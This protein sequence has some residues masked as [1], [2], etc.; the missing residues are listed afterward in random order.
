MRPEKKPLILIFLIVFIDLVGFGIVIPLHSYLS[1]QFGADPFQVGLLMSIYSLMQFLFAPFWGQ[2]SDRYGRRPILLMSLLGAAVAHMGFAFANSYLL[3]FI[4][5][6]FAGLFG[7]NISTAMAY[8]ADITPENKRSQTMGMVGAAIGLG[9]VM[10]PFIGGVFGRLG[11]QMGTAPPFGMSLGAVV[12]SLICFGNFIWA[13]RS[14]GESLPKSKRALTPKRQSVYQ[15]LASL[16][17]LLWSSEKGFLLWMYLFAAIA[18]GH[19]EVA[20]FLY[21]DDKFGWSFDQASL[22]FAYMGLIMALTQGFL[23]RK[24]MPKLG[25]RKTLIIG[26]VLYSVCLIGVGL[27][28]QIWM[29]GVAITFMGIGIGLTNPSLAGS[30]SLLSSAKEQGQ[31]MGIS[32]S[33]SS[34]GRI[35][36][37][38]MGSFLYKYY[39]PET[40]FFVGG[41]FVALTLVMAVMNYQKIPMKALES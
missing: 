8:V 3:L 4:A 10:G 25:E 22:G 6:M 13:Y 34:M 21:V 11:L 17:G 19:M 14:L 1:R 27:S 35:L 26:S 37:P 12:A 28:S 39:H 29:L 33:L 41:G 15:R 32:Q 5:R 18:M 40:P 24:L 30:I 36:G 9:F 2:I 38:L 7:A 31:M 16:T 20:M 23:V